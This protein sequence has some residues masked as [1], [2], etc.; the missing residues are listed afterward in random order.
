VHI[1]GSNI[2]KYVEFLYKFEGILPV[3]SVPGGVLIVTTEN[4]DKLTQFLKD[5]GA[6]LFVRDVALLPEDEAILGRSAS[7]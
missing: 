2:F 3:L 5:S 1:N 6:E 4:A 7:I